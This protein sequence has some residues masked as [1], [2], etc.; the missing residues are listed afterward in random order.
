MTVLEAKEFLQPSL[1]KRALTIA[2][3]RY[4]SREETDI[5]PFDMLLYPILGAASSEELEIL[6]GKR[7]PPEALQHARNLTP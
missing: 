3:G 2:F 5:F 4:L 6:R 7:L 1:N